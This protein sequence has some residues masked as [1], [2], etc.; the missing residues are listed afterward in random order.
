MLNELKKE[1]L[2]ETKPPP[3]S[4]YSYIGHTAERTKLTK[5]LR[6]MFIRHQPGAIDQA[7]SSV[8]MTGQEN[9]G[10]FL[11]YKTYKTRYLFQELVHEHIKN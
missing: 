3:P 8:D 7:H 11:S 2:I 4:V 10:N 9:E 6:R 5:Q 1:T